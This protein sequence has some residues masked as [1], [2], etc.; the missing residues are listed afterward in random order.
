MRTFRLA[1]LCLHCEGVSRAYPNW[2]EGRGTHRIKCYVSNFCAKIEKLNLVYNR[3][4]TAETIEAQ[5]VFPL[6]YALFQYVCH[7]NTN[8]F[9]L[10]NRHGRH[11]STQLITLS[12]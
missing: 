11:D 8:S 12:R 9:V 5:Q 3:E 7:N 1:H 2:Q 6:F 4:S 10:A